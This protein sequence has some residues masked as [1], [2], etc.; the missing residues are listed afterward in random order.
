MKVLKSG[1][2][3][4]KLNITNTHFLA[5][6][7]F[8]LLFFSISCEL[9]RNNPLDPES[10]PG[11]TA[12]PKVTGLEATGSGP[13][14]VSKYVELE[15][16]KN[17]IGN[18]DGYYIYRGLAYNAAYARIDTVGNVSPGTTMTRIVPITAPGFY[19]F[20][21]SAFKNFPAGRLEGP[22]SEWVIARVDN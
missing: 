3:M 10:G 2:D 5:I 20:K 11:I 19:Y 17:D 15:W 1:I 6:V 16:T 21:V 7:L 22:L 9:K 14:V 18:T 13:G 4:R 12:P 8:L